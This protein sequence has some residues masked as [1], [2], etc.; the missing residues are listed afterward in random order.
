MAERLK[1]VGVDLCTFEDVYHAAIYNG[2][3][4]LDYL[5]HNSTVSK[6]YVHWFSGQT[7]F[8]FAVEENRLQSVLWLKRYGGDDIGP[9][10][11]AALL[12][13]TASRL[14]AET[15]AMLQELLTLDKG[16]VLGHFESA[17]LVRAIVR[18]LVPFVKAEAGKRDAGSLTEDTFLN[19]RLEQEDRAIR[20]CALVHKI[21]WKTLAIGGHPIAK[22]IVRPSTG[23]TTDISVAVQ[24]FISASNT[25]QLAGLQRLASAIKC[26]FL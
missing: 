21:S 11:W 7:P 16:G 15:E 20:K 8:E 19:W 3:D 13:K 10:N 25:A 6:K 17:R 14:T 12:N 5:H 18:G 9:G 2:Q 22:D 26:L 1:R 4:F 24:K 23:L